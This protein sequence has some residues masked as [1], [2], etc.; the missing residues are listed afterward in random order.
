MR[1]LLA[2]CHSMQMQ[3]G[4]HSCTC[5]ASYLSALLGS[6]SVKLRHFLLV[7]PAG[8]QGECD[9]PSTV[10][11]TSIESTTLL[12][13]PRGLTIVHHCDVRM[14]LLTVK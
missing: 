9:Q 6:R 11:D 3:S 10:M 13:W 2:C 14:H 8:I 5:K 1:S 7:L 12:L 4:L